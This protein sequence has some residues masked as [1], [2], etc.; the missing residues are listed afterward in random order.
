MLPVLNTQPIEKQE[1][2]PA[3][4]LDVVKVWHTIQGEGPFAGVPAVFV[5]LAGCDM[6]CP[7][8]DTDYTTGRHHRSPA[9][10]ENDVLDQAAGTKTKLVVI[11]GGEPFRQ[12]CGPF[13]RKMLQ[14]GWDVQVETNGTL[15][16][17]DFPYMAVHTVC[18]PK[19][20]KVTERL[21]PWVQYLK[22]VV[23]AGEVDT[24]G[25]PLTALGGARPA[26][27]WTW[28]GRGK[29]TVYV[30]PMDEGDE[31]S[32]RLNL[33]AAVKS[34]MEHGYTLSV[35]LHKLAGLE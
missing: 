3:G 9:E 13:A 29:P 28:P 23:R 10:L 24:D 33:R 25:L 35:Q 2:S 1:L 27:P 15:A 18:S 11:T 34:C 30:Q 12:A 16:L 21:L 14:N 5:R 6:Q 4:W 19:A 22:Y 32:N 26:R 7:M 8:C 20:E 31:G 17:D